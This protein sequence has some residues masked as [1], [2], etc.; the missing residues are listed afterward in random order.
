M[1][2][3][4]VAISRENQKA[5]LTAFAATTKRQ[6]AKHKNSA[7]TPSMLH[8]YEKEIHFTIRLL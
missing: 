7:Q 8:I 5:N 6:K 1:L 4:L 2:L 3:S